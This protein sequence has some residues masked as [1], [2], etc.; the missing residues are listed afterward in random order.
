MSQKV[1]S[2]PCNKIVVFDVQQYRFKTNRHN[3]GQVGKKLGFRHKAPPP[4]PR[5]LTE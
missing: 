4:T 2:V 5:K 1:S 3:E